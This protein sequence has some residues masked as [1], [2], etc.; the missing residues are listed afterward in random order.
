MKSQRMTLL[1]CSSEIYSTKTLLIECAILPLLCTPSDKNID[2]YILETEELLK[3]AGVKITKF[4]EPFRFE[5]VSEKRKKIRKY[6]N[7]YLMQRNAEGGYF[8]SLEQYPIRWYAHWRI[9]VAD[10]V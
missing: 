5:N 10:G 2:V 4:S 3:I 7:A 6:P 1:K 9:A 8:L